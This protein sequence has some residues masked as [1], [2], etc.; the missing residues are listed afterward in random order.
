MMT[1]CSRFTL[2]ILFMSVSLSFTGY[3]YAD[4][5]PGFEFLRTEIGARAAGMGGAYVGV[6]GDV[7]SLFYNPGSI[8]FI[9]KKGA[10]ASY[11]NNVMDFNVGA[12]AYIQPISK[13]SSFGV[14][15][16]YLD[17][18]D[19]Q[20]KDEFGRDT[21]TFGANDI[22]LTGSFGRLIRRD[23][24]IGVSIKYVQSKIAGYSA[25]AI[26]GDFGILYLLPDKGVTLGI[27]LLNVGKSI[28][29]FV[30]TKEDLP[31]QVKAGITKQLTH[32]PLLISGEIRRFSDG[33]FF[34]NGGGE[35]QLRSSIR[36]RLGY[37]SVG[38]DQKLGLDS[39]RWS[40]FSIG[41]GIII[42]DMIMDYSLSSMG[43]IG[44]Q[45]RFTLSAFF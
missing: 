13:L 4:E 20:G 35:L 32:L 3:G 18:G 40:G 14:G 30:N 31:S 45:N 16:Q 27:S 29:A 5:N 19:F 9:R 33:E 15:I 7:H 34:F 10:S 41:G 37:S 17:Y 2:V 25:S 1:K 8:V 44:T 26:A 12:G 43:G 21:G 39:D 24:G 11:L 6:T 22:A 38:R 36:L 28:D 42:R 23:L